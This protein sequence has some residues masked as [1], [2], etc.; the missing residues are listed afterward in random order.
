MVP[1]AIVL[2]LCWHQVDFFPCECQ[3]DRP[4]NQKARVVE[5]HLTL[6][7][8]VIGVGMVD[9]VD[10]LRFGDVVHFA[11]GAAAVDADG[12]TEATRQVALR[13][14]S[15]PFS[16]IRGHFH[17]QWVE[18]P[19]W[20]LEDGQ[21]LC[22]GHDG[23]IHPVQEGGIWIAHVRRRLRSHCY[24]TICVLGLISKGGGEE[25]RVEER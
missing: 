8:S 15:S 22:I 10:D 18:L 14:V 5:G 3:I 17:S 24:R 9:G 11:A 16:I 23:I 21:S 20:M 6:A 4:I 13:Y 1:A 25:R 19:I 7:V 2:S 12:G